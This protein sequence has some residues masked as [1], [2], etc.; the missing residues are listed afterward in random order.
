MKTCYGLMNMKKRNLHS[1]IGSDLKFFQ[2][3]LSF[4]LKFIVWF[5]IAI[6]CKANSRNN[7]QTIFTNKKKINDF[8]VFYGSG[9]RKCTYAF[10]ESPE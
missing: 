7:N 9:S 10:Y 4:P 8:T 3:A 1:T 5:I 6:V 2:C